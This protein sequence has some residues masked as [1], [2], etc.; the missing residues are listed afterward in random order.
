VILIHTIAWI[1]LN[2]TQLKTPF[3]S[4][5]LNCNPPIWQIVACLQVDCIVNRPTRREC[6]RLGCAEY[7][8][9]FSVHGWDKSSIICR[10]HL[11]HCAG[12]ICKCLFSICTRYGAVW[13]IIQE[14]GF[15]TVRLNTAKPRRPVLPSGLGKPVAVNQGLHCW[16]TLLLELPPLLPAR[17]SS[18][19]CLSHH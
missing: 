7:V 11:C 13:R 18:A 17:P 6:L 14:P 9:E 5:P 15:K 8:Y 3:N 4:T 12:S 10:H 1:P 2:S 16:Y 19:W